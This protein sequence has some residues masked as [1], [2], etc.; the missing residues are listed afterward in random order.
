M[1]NGCRFHKRSISKGQIF[2]LHRLLFLNTPAVKKECFWT[3]FLFLVSRRAF[4]VMWLTNS[5]RHWN[6][7]KAKFN[8]Q[9]GIFSALLKNWLFWDFCK[10]TKKTHSCYS[11]NCD[12]FIL[13]LRT[14]LTFALSVCESECLIFN[15]FCVLG[16]TLTP[17]LSLS[18]FSHSRHYHT[19]TQ[20]LT[21]T[22]SISICSTN[23]WWE[24]LLSF[25]LSLSFLQTEA[26][27]VLI[28]SQQSL[29][30]FI[31][32]VWGFLMLLINIPIWFFLAGDSKMNQIESIKT[33]SFS[34]T[35]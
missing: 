18:P 25:S 2:D 7:N 5:L 30:A 17:S 10:C 15:I 28:F 27:F 11:G 13:P 6:W 26:F 24:F 12:C 35:P 34:I 20:T 33:G 8:F 19:H 3:I 9:G 22:P 14:S 31:Q 29:K 23:W 4:D 21:H 1:N 32:L 16:G